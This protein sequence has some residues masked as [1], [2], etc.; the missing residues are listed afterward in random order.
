MQSIV[1]HKNI[2]SVT[3]FQVFLGGSWGGSFRMN[4][5]KNK[6]QNAIKCDFKKH[7]ELN[8]TKRKEPINL[9]T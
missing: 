7:N 9:D 6:Q 5:D 1:Y 2:I 3:I 4:R 8:I